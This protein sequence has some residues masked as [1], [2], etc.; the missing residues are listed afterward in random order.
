MTAPVLPAIPDDYD[1]DATVL[2]SEM[3]AILGNLRFAVT[4]TRPMIKVKISGTVSVPNNSAAN[5]SFGQA[6]VDTTGMWSALT[7]SVLTMRVPGTWIFVAQATY[8]SSSTGIRGVY[9]T[10]NGD[11]ANINGF[12]GTE[13]SAST[14]TAGTFIQVA[15]VETFA[16][17]DVIRLRL[18]QNSGSAVNLRTD[19]GSTY[20]SGVWIGPSA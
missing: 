6:V 9:L 10:K 8:P 2:A 20:I 17:N 13:V 16:E 3:N 5:V 4:P 18:F 15:A 7:P 14:S 1:E 19:Y 12:C 11:A